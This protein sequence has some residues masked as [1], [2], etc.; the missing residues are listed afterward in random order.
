MLRKVL[1]GFSLLTYVVA[2]F[3]AITFF[4]VKPTDAAP[5]F[6]Y[7]YYI[8]GKTYSRSTGEICAYWTRTDTWTGSTDSHLR[9][10]S[11]RQ[12]DGFDHAPY[13]LGEEYVTETHYRDRC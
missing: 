12:G 2:L 4:A 11:T 3:G 10:Y 8:T 7:Y 5:E 1:G 13:T 9:W 6:A